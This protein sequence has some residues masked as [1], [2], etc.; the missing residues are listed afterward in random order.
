MTTH[1]PHHKKDKLADREPVLLAFAAAAT[2][3]LC[4]FI[5]QILETT[6]ILDN[7]FW[8]R[9]I[10]TGL[11]PLIGTLAALWARGRVDSPATRLTHAARR[12][13]SWTTPANQA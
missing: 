11:G 3:V 5:L 8:L 7:A 10:L 6:D 12:S 4:A 2:P 13:D 9:V 1:Q